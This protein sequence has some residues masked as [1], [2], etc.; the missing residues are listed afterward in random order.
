MTLRIGLSL[1]PTWLRGDS[2][3]QRASGAESMFSTE[4]Y[5]GPAKLAEAAQLDFLFKPDAGFL[6]PA[7]L[8]RGVGFAALDSIVLMTALAT[9]TSQI[10]LIPTISSTFAHPYTVARQ[11]QSLDQLSG[12]RVG[13]NV[14]TSLGGAQNF[15]ESSVDD[16]YA[17]ATDFV[18]MIEA[19]RQT[20]PADALLVDRR[21]GRFADIST[22]K[23]ATPRGRYASDGPIPVPAV[24]Q[25][26]WPLVHAGGSARSREFAAQYADLV[27][28]M[29]STPEDSQRQ[30][31]AL[32]AAA[33]PRRRRVGLLP[34]LALCLADTRAEAQRLAQEAGT[35][36]TG[37]HVQHWSVTGTP[38]D[39]VVAITEWADTEACDGLIVL[40][41]GSIRSLELF[42]SEVVPALV[43]S[44]HYRSPQ[45]PGPS[46]QERQR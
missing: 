9:Q 11:L 46:R 7:P 1:S 29:A 21:N 23:T 17:N 43:A 24:S 31:A 5:L 34:G 37:A 14:V 26:R 4:F 45:H 13:W 33:E 32:R 20:F 18:E 19:L 44:G 22:L 10:R 39:A 8:G 2:W 30:R 16:P 15:P 6:D 35:R 3:R 12:G 36:G 38:D 42:T 25:R 28:A 40:P 27:F 41:I